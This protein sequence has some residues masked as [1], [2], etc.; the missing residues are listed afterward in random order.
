VTVAAAWG[1]SVGPASA[2]PASV[3]ERPTGLGGDGRGDAALHERGVHDADSRAH[4]V[5]EEIERG[6]GRQDRRAEIAQDHDADSGI[7]G[8]DPGGD[9]REAGADPTVVGAA[10]RGQSGV[11]GHLAGNVDE[12]LSDQRAVGDED[13]PDGSAAHAASPDAAADAAP[14][15]YA[16]D[17]APGSRWPMARPPR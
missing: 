3:V 7:H 15:R 16:V 14:S 10:G 2:D 11:G 1:V 5:V 4:G 13:E 17:C 9:Q 6:L 12:P 8:G